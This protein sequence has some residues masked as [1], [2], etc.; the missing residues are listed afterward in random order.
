MFGVSGYRLSFSK[1]F[2][3][4]DLKPFCFRSL[5]DSEFM[6][7]VRMFF[8]LMNLDAVSARIPEPVP[9]SSIVIENDDAGWERTGE[10]WR[11]FRRLS[12]SIED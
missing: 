3:F 7:T 5:I 8:L 6:S 10:D 1:R 11:G 2:D 9:M 4:I 12:P